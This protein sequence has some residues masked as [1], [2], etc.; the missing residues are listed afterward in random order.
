[1]SDHCKDAKLL[2]QKDIRTKWNKF[3]EID[4]GALQSEGDLV[5]QIVAKYG[6]DQ[7]KAKAE[8]TALLNGR[9]F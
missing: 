3:S 2:L 8:A 9:R 4:V 7:A 1:M 6:V 5:S